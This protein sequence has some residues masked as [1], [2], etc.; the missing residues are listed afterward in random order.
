MYTKTRFEKETKG[1]G[2][3]EMV[4]SLGGTTLDSLEPTV[5]IT[6]RPSFEP[7]HAQCGAM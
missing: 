5:L 1:R 4:Y 6:Q 7:E 3:S 2:N